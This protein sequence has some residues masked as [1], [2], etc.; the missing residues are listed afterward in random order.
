V[1]QAISYLRVST[2]KQGISGLGIEAQR[3]A[4]EQMCAQRGYRLIE[5]F[6]EADSGRRN[7]R[8]QL[9][10]ARAM[11]RAAGAV[12]VVAKLDRLARD[13]DMIR[14]I[15]ASKE[16][17]VFC[18]FPQIPDG[19]MGEMMIT[20]M[21]AFAE[22]E[23]NCISKRTKDAMQAA[24]K[25]GQKFGNPEALARWRRG[26]K[27]DVSRANEA[28]QA[29]AQQ[30]INDVEP[31]IQDL[32]MKGITTLRGIASMLNFKGIKSPSGRDWKAESV[33]RVLRAI[34]DVT[35]TMQ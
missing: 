25:R 35:T 12:L 28:R 5:E 27:I 18:D 1:K 14:S 33:R 19:P 9:Q 21:A 26:R 3:H 6:V 2:D 30:K 32:R 34:P 31:V 11:A 22:F 10:R 15:M 8:P 23:S 7:D 20:L 17:V 16:Q 4:V 13:V 24:K 29:I